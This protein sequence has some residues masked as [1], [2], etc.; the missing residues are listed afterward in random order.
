VLCIPSLPALF[1]VNAESDAVDTATAS[2]NSATAGAD[3]ATDA[4]NPAMDMTS[5]SS[6]MTKHTWRELKV[7]Q[8]EDED[9]IRHLCNPA[10]S[11]DPPTT[12]TKLV[13]YNIVQKYLVMS[14]KLIIKRMVDGEPVYKQEGVVEEVDA[15]ATS[16]SSSQVAIAS[17]TSS[18]LNSAQ[19]KAL[20]KGQ[21]HAQA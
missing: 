4:V 21:E 17:L 9:I 10:R 19:L 1:F 14:G 20:R 15:S 3:K 13:L 18:Q 11:A 7:F 6:V 16:A 8:E 12:P 2:A 5:T